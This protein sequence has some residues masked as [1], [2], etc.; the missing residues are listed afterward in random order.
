MAL[1]SPLPNAT[2]SL[3]TYALTPV[4][5]NMCSCSDTSLTALSKAV[6]ELR[7]FPTNVT[8]L[9]RPHFSVTLSRR[10]LMKLGSCSSTRVMILRIASSTPPW[11]FLPLPP[12][13]SLHYTTYPSCNGADWSLI[14]ILCRPM[15]SKPILWYT[16]RTSA[17]RPTSC[18]CRDTKFSGV[19]GNRDRLFPLFSRQK[20]WPHTSIAIVCTLLLVTM[21][22]CTR[23][24]LQFCYS[25]RASPPDIVF[26]LC[27]CAFWLR[28]TF[29]P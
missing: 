5:A 19:N 3:V 16:S 15:M 20:R 7:F 10:S 24:G 2:P 26:C 23:A 14:Q 1:H 9:A 17:A 18:S 4:N 25:P 11:S 27:F 22:S 8:A 6:Q 13:S 12:L 29:F 28:F 21:S